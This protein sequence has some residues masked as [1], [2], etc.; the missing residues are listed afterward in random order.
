MTLLI[1]I[2]VLCASLVLIPLGLPGRW[3]MIA[4]AV[5][6]SFYIPGSIGWLVIGIAA[7]AATIAEVLEWTLGA[8]YT[9]KYGGSTRASWGAFVGGLVGAFM[10]VPVPIMGP[11]I[12]GFL[13]AFA[14]ALVAELSRGTSLDAATTGGKG[15]GESYDMWDAVAV[16]WNWSL[17]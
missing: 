6:Y 17:W 14:G 7:A 11:V 9:K 5:G 4:A 15:G 13:G 8:K 3:I 16:I 1:L 10:G 12:G 2:I